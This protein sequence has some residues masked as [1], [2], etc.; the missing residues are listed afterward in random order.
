[1]VP[2]IARLE[3]R[4]RALLSPEVYDFYAGGSG[5]ES[6]LRANVK[7]WRRLWLAPRVLRDVSSVDTRLTLWGTE[8]RTPVAVAPT[9]FH[10]LA[11]PEGEVATAAAAA[12]AGALFVLSTRSSCRIEDVG[13]AV[14]QAGGTWWF[15][16][17]VMRDRELT[18]ALV[19]RAVA[20]GAAAL[21][22]TADTPVVGRKRRSR[23][24]RSVTP[25][26]FSASTGPLADPGAAEQ[27]ADVTFADIGWL[28]GLG[29][30]IPVLVKGVLRADD[31]RACVAAGAAGVIVSNHG[32]RQLDRALP[33]AFALALVAAA[34]RYEQ[35]PTGRP[36]VH[37]DG[38][39]RSGEDALAA[40]ASGAGRV[41]LG[42]P[43]LWALACGGAP[44]VRDLLTG[45]TEDLG[46]AMALA[47]AA[48]LADLPGLVCPGDAP[49]TPPR[50]TPVTGTRP[51]PPPGGD[52]S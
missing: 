12:Q 20:A 29:G 18:A 48:T 6:T 8:L 35:T 7:A 31:A 2:D 52:A 32:G 40:V 9:A 33:T 19:R 4:A 28:A 14:A 30:G 27:A 26:I 16:A 1:M 5:Q 17:Y 10:R 44:A 50:G 45:L 36:A 34:L 42:R 13:A 3:R 25:E 46:H 23:G 43:V 38:G 41:F 49:R 51:E 15:Q 37:V 24:E 47:G 21:V 11:Y 22:L 39:V